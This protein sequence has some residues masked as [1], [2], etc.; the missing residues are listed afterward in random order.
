MNL[1]SWKLLQ[2]EVAM[3]RSHFQKLATNAIARHSVHVQLSRNL[4]DCTAARLVTVKHEAGGLKARPGRQ[5]LQVSK[6]T[7]LGADTSRDPA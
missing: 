4:E 2:L 3:G 6:W 1:Q 7:S 5:P